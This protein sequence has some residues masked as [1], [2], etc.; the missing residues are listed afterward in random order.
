MIECRAATFMIPFAT[1][2]LAAGASARMGRPKMLLPW[3]GT[4]VIAHLIDL[5]KNAG[6]RQIGVVCRADDTGLH[7]ELE[8]I[9]FPSCD[10]IINADPSRGMFSSIQCAARREGWDAALTHWAVALGDQPHL[11]LTTLRSVIDGAE[12]HPS[13]I[14]QPSR[15][16]RPRHPVFLPHHLWQSVLG[17]TH[18]TL[19]DFLEAHAPDR[20]LV[21]VDDPG[22]DLDLDEP[23]DYEEALRLVSKR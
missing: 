5:W 18:S 9:G 11:S 22:L 19:K 2:I 8:R 12:Q 21:E 17:S 13:A 3:N 23:S 10:R 7:S 16:H 4:T 15:H 14:C 6:A 1:I 20:Y